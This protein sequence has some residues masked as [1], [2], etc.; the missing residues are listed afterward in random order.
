MQPAEKDLVRKPTDAQQANMAAGYPIYGAYLNK[1]ACTASAQAPNT[2]LT[3]QNQY[4]QGSYTASAAGCE[5][6]RAAI[7]L[8]AESAIPRQAFKAAT[9]ATQPA[10]QSDDLFTILL[11]SLLLGNSQNEGKAKVAEKDNC[12]CKEKEK[13]KEKDKCKEKEK[14]KKKGCGCKT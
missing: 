5:C 13:D 4:Y 8:N 3:P 12:G 2:S 1:G 11:L 6:G 9:P 14:D 10:S 7:P